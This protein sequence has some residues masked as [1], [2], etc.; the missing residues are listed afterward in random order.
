[1]T[2]RRREILFGLGLLVPLALGLAASEWILRAREAANKDRDVN[3][4]A[5]R[6]T[7]GTGGD[8]RLQFKPGA[9]FGQLRFNALGF[10]GPEVAMPKPGATIRVLFLGDSKTFA[11]EV[12]EDQAFPAQGIAQ[13]RKL[14]PG[15]KFDYVNISGPAYTLDDLAALVKAKRDVIAPDLVVV[16]A[17]SAGNLLKLHGNRHPPTQPP[18]QNSTKQSTSNLTALL[19][20][21]VAAKWVSREIALI[22]PVTSFDNFPRQDLAL[23]TRKQQMMLDTL[24]AAIGDRPVVTIAYRTR[25]KSAEG[26]AANWL[27]TRNF[28]IS[29]P[30]TSP[31]QTRAIL[32]LVI[33]QSRTHA[34]A[35]GWD[36]IDPLGAMVRDPAYYHDRSHFSP[37]G[38]AKIGAAVADAAARQVTAGCKITG[39]TP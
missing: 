8:E 6:A 4:S 20:Q 27:N 16:L 34:T 39:R 3:W 33:N 5:L 22:S 17:G 38:H 26:L 32:K 24:A 35:T 25:E 15:C 31:A 10:R 21:S 7:A 2:D 13:L 1:M 14:R 29:F 19:D 23:L 30:G 12:S 18:L 11:G 9:R 36:Y 28:R 37:L